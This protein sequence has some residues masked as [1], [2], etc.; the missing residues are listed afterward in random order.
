MVQ[1]R[2]LCSQRWPW[3][4][5][6]VHHFASLGLWLHPGLSLVIFHIL[7]PENMLRFARISS[8]LEVN[9]TFCWELGPYDFPI[10]C[11]TCGAWLGG[12]GW[13]QIKSDLFR[14]FEGQA[15]FS[16]S[17]CDPQWTVTMFLALISTLRRSMHRNLAY[18]TWKVVYAKELTSDRM[19]CWVR[20]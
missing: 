13:I 19:S 10:G 18:Q 3:M 2:S 11:S 6:A 20:G 12:S 8:I 16:T 5:L 14:S 4:P 7:L 17:S 9:G 1:P 15:H